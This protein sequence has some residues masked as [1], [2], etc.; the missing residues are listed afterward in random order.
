MSVGGEG[1]RPR[2]AYADNLV[3]RN[4][5]TKREDREGIFDT[6]SVNV[7]VAKSEKSE[8]DNSV[9]THSPDNFDSFLHTSKKLVIP[10][11]G[12]KVRYIKLPK[13][14]FHKWY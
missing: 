2:S 9:D 13:A 1:G 8:N 6:Y 3:Q 11:T 5:E 12:Q 7:N 4:S 10:P 14:T